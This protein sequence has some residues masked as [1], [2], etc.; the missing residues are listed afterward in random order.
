[1]KHIC[2]VI[3]CILVHKY[4]FALSVIRSNQ[5]AE[6]SLFVSKFSATYQSIL[7]EGYVY[8]SHNSEMYIASFIKI[9][10]A[11]DRSNFNKNNVIIGSEID[12]I[13]TVQIPLKNFIKFIESP[14]IK[15]ITLDRP[16]TME[17]DT[18]RK[19]SLVEPVQEGA[20]PL[21]QSYTGKGVV[22]GV[23]DAGFDY[24]H[25]NFYDSTMTNYRVKRIW[26]Q[27]KSG[28]PP[29]GFSYGN[30]LKDSLSMMNAGTD[31]NITHGS[32]V[33]GIIAGSG[34]GGNIESKRYRGVA[35]DADIVLVGI[36]PSPS[37]WISTGMTDII[38]GVKYI[39]DYAT[40]IG[41]PAVANL[42]WGC[43]IGPH[44]GNSLFSKAL[45]KLIGDGKIFVLS[46][47]NNGTNNIH[48]SKQFMS[49]DT[50]VNSIINFSPNLA[51]KKTW[52]DIW[53]D[54]N[55]IFDV[56]ISL[57]NGTTKVGNS[58]MM[59]LNNLSTNFILVGQNSDTCFVS[60]ANKSV[61]YNGRTHAFLDIY[62]KTNLT[63]VLTEKATSGKIN[64]WM[65]FVQNTTG[66]YGSFTAGALPYGKDG[67]NI[68]TCGD[69]AS[70]KTAIAVAAFANKM[71][72]KNINNSNTTLGYPNTVKGG[73][74]S[75]S[76]RGPTL[77][78]RVKPDI[79]GPGVGIASSVSSYDPTFN[80]AGSSYASNISVFIHPITSKKYYFGVLSGTSMSSPFVTGVVALLLEANKSLNP[81]R[82]KN[83]LTVNAIKDTFT[84]A[85]NG[86]GSNTWGAGKVNALNSI[87]QAIVMLEIISHHIPQ[88]SFS[89]YPNPTNDFV[90]I[91]L[92]ESAKN[93][94]VQ[95]MNTDG[96]SLLNEE[97]RALTNEILLDF[98]IFSKGIYF[99][100][101]KISGKV[102]VVK[103]GVE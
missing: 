68:S 56:E 83:I 60:Y 33:A 12:N 45:D 38:D 61:E 46:A 14:H 31:I 54:S 90:K 98:S 51:E 43:I 75:F 27:K 9:E 84:G 71:T 39:F 30:E 82:I 44:D 53:G 97:Y 17:M 34:K 49:I 18:A 95:V 11:F 50:I 1:M 3:I 25:P 13:F 55:Q 76:S 36:T 66:Y 93:I 67:D 62:N 22:V 96:K 32:H 48:L 69:M 85:I 19:Y 77:D 8:K 74:A 63:V 78:G 100:K 86:I 29:S 28:T 15:M 102:E 65:G 94:Y 72:F 41:K 103:V 26:E 2:I 87:K 42:S 21:T 4:S 89:I 64:T 40:S 20:F 23:I 73:I 5:S 59:E 37:N 99:I 58:A 92:K 52:V 10:S 101:M 80:L 91:E 88:S 70:T 57:Y 24:T 79:T 6:T 35:F 16:V 7:P 47:G 81:E